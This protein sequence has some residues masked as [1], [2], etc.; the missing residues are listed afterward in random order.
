MIAELGALDAALDS[1]FGSAHEVGS[2]MLAQEAQCK[3]AQA[4]PSPVTVAAPWGQRLAWMG[5]PV[6][7]SLA[8]TNRHSGI[9]KT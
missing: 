6:G 8:V 3:E 7:R 9:S 5:L 2:C 4:G 1:A